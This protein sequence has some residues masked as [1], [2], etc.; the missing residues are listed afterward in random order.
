[1]VLETAA[2]NHLCNFG[3]V[4]ITRAKVDT[5]TVYLSDILCSQRLNMRGFS[6]IWKA[7][8]TH[9]YHLSTSDRDD[10]RDRAS[11]FMLLSGG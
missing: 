2:L 9:G 1:M 7:F 11:E 6:R 8:K 4:D 5:V 3:A 10:D